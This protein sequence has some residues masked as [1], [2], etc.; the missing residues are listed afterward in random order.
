MVIDWTGTCKFPCVT[1][2]LHV[3]TTP[4][5]VPGTTVGSGLGEP[6]LITAVY[7]DTLVTG[8]FGGVE[9]Q[10]NGQSFTLRAT[11]G[12]GKGGILVFEDEFRS[13]ADGTWDLTSEGL[14]QDAATSGCQ[15]P[16]P[17]S[18]CTYHAQGTGGT[19]TISATSSTTQELLSG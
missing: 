8:N 9:W 18:F 6:Q 11:N 16:D 1:A 10:T 14:F 5:Y 17:G 7:T 15:H 3:V 19:W 2:N 13:R 4:D 12:P